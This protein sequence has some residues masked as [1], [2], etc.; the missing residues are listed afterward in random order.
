M[1][2]FDL[3]KLVEMSVGILLLCNIFVP[4]AL[5]LEMPISVTIFF[6]SSIVIQNDRSIWS[7]TRELGLNLFLLAAY[8]GYY[9]PM[10]RA[11]TDIAP[12]WRRGTS[13]TGQGD[14]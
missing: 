9:W 13:S 5:V 10:L 3:V 2:L 1:G 4:L 12:L 6:L 7:G 14:A 8:A 11:R